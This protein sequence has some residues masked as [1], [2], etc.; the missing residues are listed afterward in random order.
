MSIMLIPTFVCTCLSFQRLLP[1]GPVGALPLAGPFLPACANHCTTAYPMSLKPAPLMGY[2]R[3]T[4]IKPQ[5]LGPPPSTLAD[6]QT[7][8]DARHALHTMLQFF[9][10]IPTQL[11]VVNYRRPA[12]KIT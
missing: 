11:Y 12:G 8:L 6:K 10:I 1:R 9:G 3:R 2:C 7:D 5:G 4:L